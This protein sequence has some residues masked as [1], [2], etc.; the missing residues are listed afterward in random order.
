MSQ[1]NT[2]E[3]AAENLLRSAKRNKV[4]QSIK[5]TLKKRFHKN[6]R[7]LFVSKERHVFF[8]LDL[9]MTKPTYF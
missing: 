6:K 3:I 1:E 9:K 2:E 8:I 5:D 7:N 4:A